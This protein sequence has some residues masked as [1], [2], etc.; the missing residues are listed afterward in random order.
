MTSFG[1]IRRL[2][3]NTRNTN[4]RREVWM[5]PRLQRA[6]HCESSVDLGE[7]VHDEN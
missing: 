2:D 4:V 7:N 6:E 3:L 5:R 1:T